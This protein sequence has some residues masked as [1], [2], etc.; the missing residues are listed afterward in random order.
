MI[1]EV[2]GSNQGLWKSLDAVKNNRMFNL[3]PELFWGNDPVSLKLQIQEIVKML[4]E[5]AKQ[6]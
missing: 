1:S 3:D 6:E 2:W 4:T 5:Q